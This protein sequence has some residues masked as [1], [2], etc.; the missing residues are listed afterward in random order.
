[1]YLF[2][3]SLLQP[4]MAPLGLTPE[5]ISVVAGSM[6]QRSQWINLP[7]GESGSSIIRT[8]DLA[9]LGTLPKKKLGLTLSP[10]QVKVMG[11]SPPLLKSG[12]V[13]SIII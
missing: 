13:K 4:I 5:I 6:F 10:S 2:L 8:S 7:E 11:M 3:P 12:L 1:M 9:F